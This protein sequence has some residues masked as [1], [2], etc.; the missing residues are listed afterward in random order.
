MSDQK[1][2]NKQKAPHCGGDGGGWSRAGRQT[3]PG[4]RGQDGGRFGF[5]SAI[6]VA[7]V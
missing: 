7:I 4:I 3:N 2:P 6:A 5:L 1:A